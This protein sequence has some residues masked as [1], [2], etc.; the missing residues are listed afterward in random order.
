MG[1][2]EMNG[3]DIREYARDRRI[4]R[5]DFIIAKEIR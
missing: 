2:D 1:M 3:N 4:I 5:I